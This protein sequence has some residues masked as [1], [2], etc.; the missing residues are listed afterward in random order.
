VSICE[1]ASTLSIEIRENGW[2]DF[3][4]PFHL[5]SSYG[6]QKYDITGEQMYK[7]QDVRVP[8][9]RYT[10]GERCTVVDSETAER[11]DLSLYNIGRLTRL[12]YDQTKQRSVELCN[13]LKDQRIHR[14][15][16]CHA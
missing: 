3:V 6:Y 15:A 7:Y 10:N 1:L 2:Q 4:V 16:D 13:W 14:L 9:Y 11:P 5:V 12:H 8:L